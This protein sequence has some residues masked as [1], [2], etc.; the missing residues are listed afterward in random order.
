MKRKLEDVIDQ[1]LVWV[2]RQNKQLVK[3]LKKCKE[4]A[5]KHGPEHPD[6]YWTWRKVAT[7]LS[8]EIKIP[9]KGWHR[10]VSDA[11]TGKT[12]KGT[13]DIVQEVDIGDEDG[14]GAV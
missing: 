11:F 9:P 2:P 14:S 5:A 4:E 13:D 7:I 12:A 8:A 10:R 1:I 6:S 3:A